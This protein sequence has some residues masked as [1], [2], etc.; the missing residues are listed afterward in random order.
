LISTSIPLRSVAAFAIV[1]STWS[2]CELRPVELVR[3]ARDER[4]PRTLCRELARDHQPEAARS[5]DD[6]DGLAVEVDGVHLAPGACGGVAGG[7]HTESE[8]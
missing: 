5:A 1:R 7:D 3:V 2:R 8:R 6:D 4:Q